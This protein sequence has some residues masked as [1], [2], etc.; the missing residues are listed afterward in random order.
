MTVTQ[1]NSTAA[2]TPGYQFASD[3][4]AGICPEAWDALRE[5]DRGAAPGYGED[6]WT[7]KAA[8]AL[9]ELFETDCEVFFVY[10][11]TA[12]NS[13]AI[14]HLCSS[15]HS[16]ICHQLAHI[17]TDECGGP[18]FFTNGTKLLL[19][20]GEAGKVDPKSVGEIV[21]RRTDIHYPKPR[22]LSLSQS[23]EV[24]T[25]YTVDELDALREAAHRYH[26]RVHMDGARFANAM[27]SLGVPPKEVT[28]KV[29]ID[30]LCFGGTKNGMP[31]GDAI[32]FFDN[33][34]AKEFG[35]RCKQSGQLASKMRYL[36]APW[37]GMLQS[38]AWLERARHANACA[39]KLSQRLTAIPGVKLMQAVRANAVFVSLP[40]GVTQALKE[41]GWRFYTFIGAGGA[42]FMC[43]WATSEADIDALVADVRAAA[44]K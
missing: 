12:A 25:V 36:S 5:A 7:A 15:Y 1:A 26:L 40:Q 44:G 22:V 6:A 16:V 32:V 30:V 21:N 37:V 24:G 20:S 18:E 35:Y 11:G 27:A 31:V 39:Q 14:G 23:T 9:R 17:E 13:L 38:G 34:A 10:N 33:E 28:W 42:R 2:V 41:K 3:N 8:D 19:S 43:S 4:A 29:G